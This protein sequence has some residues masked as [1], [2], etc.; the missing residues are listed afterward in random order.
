MDGYSDVSLSS[1]SVRGN[2]AQLKSDWYLPVHGTAFA[3]F[4]TD[5]GIIVRNSTRAAI[6]EVRFKS[7]KAFPILVNRSSEVTL[8]GIRIEDSGTLNR[9]GRKQQDRRY[10]LGGG[11]Y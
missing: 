10:L 9:A 1:F 7:I 11:S 6:H 5:N 2:R 3:D 4:C 8:E